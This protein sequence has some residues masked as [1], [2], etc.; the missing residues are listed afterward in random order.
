MRGD[1][2]TDT[3]HQERDGRG[4]NVRKGRAAATE[5]SNVAATVDLR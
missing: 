1:L 4:E 5:Q 2:K 3:Q